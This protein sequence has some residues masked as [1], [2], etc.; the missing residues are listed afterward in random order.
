MGTLKTGGEEFL[1]SQLST[2]TKHSAL[3]AVRLSKLD[4]LDGERK[5]PLVLDDVFTNLDK[6]RMESVM[7]YLRSTGRQVILTACY[8]RPKT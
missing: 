7:Q 8:Q 2:G 4:R 6:N 1:F 3:F 5:V